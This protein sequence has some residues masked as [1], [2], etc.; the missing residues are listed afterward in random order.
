MSVS[1][2]IRP[3][4]PPGARQH[5]RGPEVT[6]AVVAALSA[7]ALTAAA[8]VLPSPLILPLGSTLLLLFA[9]VVALIAVRAPRHEPSRVSYWDVSGALTLIGIFAALLSDP[10]HVLPLLEGTTARK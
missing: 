10:E 4:S 5:F 7:V 9:C 8:T 3:L 6:F 2:P 1:K